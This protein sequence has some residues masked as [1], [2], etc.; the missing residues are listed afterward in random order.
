MLV[1]ALTWKNGYASVQF[2]EDAAE[3][4]HVDARGVRN[5]EDNLWRSVEA[6]LDVGI[7]P[8]V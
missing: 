2:H 4:P 8:L 3:T 7:D 6:R 5:T 1:L